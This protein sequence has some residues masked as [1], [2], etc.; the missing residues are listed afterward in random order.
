MKGSFHA[1]TS[2][3]Y[4]SDSRPKASRSPIRSHALGN[5][6]PH[7]AAWR[8][9]PAEPGGS[10]PIAVSLLVVLAT[11][12]PPLLRAGSSCP[13]SSGQVARNNRLK[14]ADSQP[15]AVYLPPSYSWGDQRY[16]V[17]YLLPQFL[18]L[19]I[20]GCIPGV[21]VATGR[22]RPNQGRDYHEIIVVIQNDAFPGDGWCRNSELTGNWED[23]ITR[24]LISYIDDR[25]EPSLAGM[26]GL[27]QDTEPGHQRSG[28]GPETF[29][30]VWERLCRQARQ[31]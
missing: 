2:S 9:S 12:A 15:A 3:G 1:S 21:Q 5:C 30:S 22:R 16:P 25:F 8:S 24:D 27:W 17:I 23:F 19:A 20:H 14:I 29:R 31:S 10:G 13:R 4:V 6:Q 26:H 11:P 28:T 7:A 18:P